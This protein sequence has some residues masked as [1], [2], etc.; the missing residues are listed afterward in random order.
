MKSQ[1]SHM[2]ASLNMLAWQSAY[3]WN[4]IPKLPVSIMFFLLWQYLAKAN[5]ERNMHFGWQFKG[6]VYHGKDGVTAVS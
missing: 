5:K 2:T 3:M 1:N 4:K 6:I